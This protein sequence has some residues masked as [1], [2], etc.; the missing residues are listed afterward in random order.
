VFKLE[1][2][3]SILVLSSIRA[4]IVLSGDIVITM[5]EAGELAVCVIL[6]FNLAVLTQCR[7]VTDGRMDL[8]NSIHRA[9][10]AVKIRRTQ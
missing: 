3:A 1:L 2:I 10:P 9:C 5:H 6:N 8:N 7:L 4:T